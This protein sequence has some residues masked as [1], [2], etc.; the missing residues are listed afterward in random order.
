MF[1]ELH[2]AEHTFALHLLLQRLK[3]L[4]DIIVSDE[5][6]HVVSSLVSLL[7]GPTPWRLDR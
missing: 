6:L 7:I 5:N 2:L 3:G 4:V 1:A